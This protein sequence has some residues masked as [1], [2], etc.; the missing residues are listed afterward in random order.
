MR[1]IAEHR[2]E[3]RAIRA[4]AAHG[5]RHRD[6]AAL[7]FARQHLAAVFEQAGDAGSL[8]A[9]EIFEHAVPAFGRKQIG[10]IASREFVAVVA[11]QRF[12]AAVG[13]MDVALGVE[14]HDAFGR[15]VEDGGEFFG[16]GMANGRR[17][18]DVRLRYRY[19]F[20]LRDGGRDRCALMAG[21]RE[22]Q[23]QRRIAVP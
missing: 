18:G 13:R 16:V 22:D 10:E 8:D 7:A 2:E 5:H 6:D 11:E 19:R 20:C 21:A 9:G 14:H 1:E 17:F 15:G 12:G 3:I 4:G 23:G